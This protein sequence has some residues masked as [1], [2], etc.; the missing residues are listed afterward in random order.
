MTKLHD[1]VTELIQTLRLNI[2]DKEYEVSIIK[3]R[4]DALLE[5]K[6]VY[7][8]QP[9]ANGHRGFRSTRTNVCVDCKNGRNDRFAMK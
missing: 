9:C 3:A 4:V 7:R 6:T 8:G 2:A 5:T 1:K